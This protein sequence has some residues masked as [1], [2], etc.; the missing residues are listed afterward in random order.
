[1]K[2]Y[3]AVIKVMEEN[4]G[5]ATLSYL[6]E[7]VLKI[8]ECVWKTKTPFASIRR[9]VQERDEIFKIKPGLWALKKYKDKL[10]PDVKALMEEGQNKLSKN[11]NTHTYYQLLLVEIGNLKKFQT[12]VPAQDKN[13]NFA[14]KRLKDI[15]TI[16]KIPQFTYSNIVKKVKSI[17]TFWFNERKFPADI[18]EIEHTTHFKNSLLKFLE[19]QDFKTN[20]FIVADSNKKNEFNKMLSLN[21]FL[22][23][24]NIVK[25]LS[26]E[27]VA[28]WHS[29][30][31]EL[32]VVENY[33]NI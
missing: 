4:N 13:K 7:N 5:F 32:M 12:Y 20:M 23:I 19:L 21:A 17:D 30:L 24:K 26:F 11:E 8:K 31:T 15:V 28:K 16:E 33:L 25:F 9:I 10:P 3:E 18:F 2:Q 1:M 29:K 14:N 27:E 6:Y 22:P